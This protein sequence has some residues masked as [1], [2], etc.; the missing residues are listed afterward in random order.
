MHD[1]DPEAT[2]SDASAPLVDYDSVDD[3]TNPAAPR[4]MPE[5]AR[6]A[7]EVLAREAAEQRPTAPGETYL[8]PGWLPVFDPRTPSSRDER[9]RADAA[10]RARHCSVSSC[11]T[12]TS[13]EE[14]GCK[15]PAR[16]AR[17]APSEVINWGVHGDVID[18]ESIVHIARRPEESRSLASSPAPSADAPALD[19]SVAVKSDAYKTR[20]EL[21]SPTFKRAMADVLTAGSVKYSDHNWRKGFA[22]SRLMGA[23]ERHFEAIKLG[24]LTDPETGKL[25]TAHLACEVMFLHDHIELGLGVNDLPW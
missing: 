3:L 24:E 2:Q 15:K 8:A 1:F 9:A 25:H 18:P 7:R 14:Y 19:L 22:W 23:I 11:S 16:E 13:C 5:T 4:T 6:A 21:I 12:P 17:V 10:Q 20:Y